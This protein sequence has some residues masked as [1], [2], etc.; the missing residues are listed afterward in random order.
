MIAGTIFTQLITTLEENPTLKKYIKYVYQGLRSEIVPDAM[1]CICI[2]PTRNNETETDMNVY[3]R[4]FASFDVY[5]F[6][7]SPIDQ[8][9]C[10]VGNNDYKGILDVENDIRACLQASNT[11]G[12]RVYDIQFEP[13]DFAYYKDYAVR[14]LVI[15]IKVLYIQENTA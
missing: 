2:E 9:K 14:G 5:A 6:T 13:T 12:N 1:P 15:P 11:L 4:L 7:Y 3:K 10:I 8:E